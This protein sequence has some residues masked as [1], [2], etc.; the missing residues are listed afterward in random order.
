MKPLLEVDNLTVHFPAGRGL[1]TRRR[2]IVHAV[3][4]ISFS[5][6]EGRTLGVVGESGC[7]K[8]TLGLAIL[9]LIPL[10]SGR[11]SFQGQDLSELNDRRMR[12]FRR[13]MQ[14]IFQDPYS[15]L[16]PR[17]RI[18]DAIME[19]M[20]V[21][22]VG[23]SAG[24]RKDK[25]ME[26]L[27]RVN[28]DPSCY[29]RYPHEFSGGQRQRV[30]IARALSV[31]PQCL[32]CDESVSALDASIQAQVLNLLHELRDEF[33]FTYIF[34]SHDLSVVKFM[35]DRMLVMNQ[36]K[37]E[38]MGDADEIYSDPKTDY[39]RKLI[40]AI[41]KGRLDRITDKSG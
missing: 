38:E 25:V 20:K 14:I 40:R 26:L 39:T 27:Q 35:S 2:Q 30:C 33:N 32:I 34:I 24:E 13:E 37:I 3:D 28:L 11:V 22:G 6:A 18:G 29:D 23:S 41:P 12:R 19:P 15:S 1:L 8:T 9:K 7:G 16:N 17:V 21:H 36:G 5:L 4:G 31:N 10:T